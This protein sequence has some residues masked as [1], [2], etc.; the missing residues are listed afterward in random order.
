MSESIWTLRQYQPCDLATL[1]DAIDRV[2]IRLGTPGSP[3]IPLTPSDD[4]LTR[5]KQ[6]ITVIAEL[7][8]AKLQSLCSL[9]L[10]SIDQRDWLT[11][12]LAGR[13]LIEHAATLRYYLREKIL[14]LVPKDGNTWELSDQTLSEIQL[15]L[16]QLIRGGRFDWSSLLEQWLAGIEIPEGPQPAQPSQVNVLTCI[17]KW[18]K[19]EPRVEQLY[20]MFCD[21][22]HP[23]LGS[24]LLVIGMTPAEISFGASCENSL[25]EAITRGTGLSIHSVAESYLNAVERLRAAVVSQ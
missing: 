16:F 3:R 17:Q 8:A 6:Q 21:L 9:V 14:P 7:S 13:S 24:S 5:V 12:G 23:N 20:A 10:Y 2:H 22:V 15:L 11:Y 18:N 25:G 1:R 19:E 4:P